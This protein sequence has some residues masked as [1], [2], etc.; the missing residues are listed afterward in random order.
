MP[1]R[2]AEV[3]AQAVWDG[4][5]REW[6]LA[7]HDEDGREHGLATFWRPDGTLVNHCNFVHGV[8]HGWFKRYHESGEVSR[9]G[10]FVDGE[11]HGTDARHRSATPTTELAFPAG[12]LPDPI[13]RYE[14]DWVHGQA[15]TARWY[16]RD[17][18]QVTKEGERYPERPTTVPDTAIYASEGA[19]WLDGHTDDQ[20]QEHGLWRS[21]SRDGTPTGEREMDHGDEIAVRHFACAEDAEATVALR[22]GHRADAAAAARRW[23]QRA[24]TAQDRILA[25]ELLARC[26]ADTES[27]ER[28]ELYTAVAD[29]PGVA[30]VFTDEGRRCHQAQ[31][32]ALDWLARDALAAGRVDDAV[33]LC[34]RAIATEHHYGPCA[35]RVTKVA[36][37][38]RL[39]RDDEA[40]QVA[41]A[42]LTAD[43]DTAGLD[44]VRADPDFAA[45]LESIRTDTM[46]TEGAW[47]ILGERG[48]R[49]A[50]IAALHPTEADSQRPSGLDMAWPV[51]EV[52]GE[53]LSPE[54]NRWID[55]AAAP[56]APAVTSTVAAAV[57]ANDGTWLA[58]MEGLF[59]PVSA[60]LVVLEEITHATWLPGP[61]GTSQVFYT[62]QDEPG[63]WPTHR[64]LAGLLAHEVLEQAEYG[65]ATV[66]GAVQ[67]RW[68]RADQ[69]LDE[70]PEPTFAA[71][72]SVPD[73]YPRTGWIVEHLSGIHC[74]HGLADA[75]GL[76]EWA[77]EREHAVVWPHLQAYWL[78]HHLV[79]DNREEL[80]FLV[81]HAERRHPAV[82]ELAGMAD[83][84][85]AGGDV[86]ADWWDATAVRGLRTRAFDQGHARLMSES[87]LAGVRT[88]LSTRDVAVEEAA[89]ARAALV[90]SG[91]AAVTEVFEVWDVLESAAGDLDTYEKVLADEL[92]PDDDRMS[93][94]LRQHTG[95]TSILLRLSAGLVERV[96]PAY[97]AFFDAAVR[98][99]VGYDE[100]HACAV[101]GAIAGLGAS[102]DD[103]GSFQ[104]RVEE[105]LGAENLGRLR[106]AELALVAAH[107]FTQQAA[108]D[109]LV[110]EA[111]RYADLLADGN[112]WRYD[113]VMYSLHRL[114]DLEPATGGRVLSDAL[115]GT[116]FT[117]ANWSS[118]IL[119]ISRAAELG[120]RE[121]APGVLAAFDRGLGRHDD[122]SRAVV[123]TSYAACAGDAAVAELESRLSSVDGVRADCERCALLAGLVTAVPGDTG[124]HEQARALIGALLDDALDGMATGAAISLLKAIDEAGVSGFGDLAARVRT[125]ADEDSTTTKP[126]LAWLSDA[127]SRG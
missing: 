108:R 102:T 124:R 64:S 62:H 118:S 113:T 76:D 70:E 71:H 11:L 7:E 120:I 99:G 59:L 106:R 90:E 26:L 119:L 1:E 55:V 77:A 12:R 116:R 122:G 103:F 84:L 121:A 98:G 92:V 49:L 16:D 30:W 63:F 81:E 123:A 101:P 83:V 68:Q 80:A 22:A 28:R 9:E 38:R 89:A 126:L 97:R 52:L 35:A 14:V 117:G 107:R 95:Q 34:D 3:P 47:Q 18:N 24:G 25:G 10:T 36:A 27:D 86:T 96:G 50:S 61:R 73:L 69:L 112:N 60:V 19:A 85:L 93:Y 79:F 115:A 33:S 45:W 72:L 57:A 29:E 82:A 87:A 6:V 44:D 56:F 21:W 111:T 40:F 75:P 105:L 39:G 110:G 46:T 23:W 66:S 5:D 41:R 114:L 58:R 15:T 125:R 65:Q 54:L 94:L 43:P 42:V 4:G 67:E 13:W 53:R 88:G 109:Y 104:D 74:E 2:P 20:G 78:F 127:L 8:P 32:A 91:A 17:G 31:A 37:L 100:S 51:R 48:E